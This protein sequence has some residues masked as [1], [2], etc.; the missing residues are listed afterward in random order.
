MEV[1]TLCCGHCGHL[2]RADFRSLPRGAR[3][4]MLVHGLNQVTSHLQVHATRVDQQVIMM[5]IAPLATRVRVVMVDAV[6]VDALDFLSIIFN[7]LIIFFR[8]AADGT[9]RI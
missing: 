2:L 3:L 8:T 9:L 7:R 6:P 5:G 4:P 1:L